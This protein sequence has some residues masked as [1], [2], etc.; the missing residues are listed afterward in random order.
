MNV[1]HAMIYISK[2]SMEIRNVVCFFELI[3]KDADPKRKGMQGEKAQRVKSDPSQS[4]PLIF[5]F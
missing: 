1:R 3:T 5:L 4:T 2:C